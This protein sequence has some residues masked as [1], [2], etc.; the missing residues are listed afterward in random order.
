MFGRGSFVW[1]YLK[2]KL[3]V[4]C[5]KTADLDPSK[6]Y[7]LG[8]HPHGILP[9]G[10]LTAFMDA[11]SDGFSKLFPSVDF[12]IL[13][14]SFCFY[15]PIYRDFLLSCGVIDASRFSAARALNGGK[16]L[17]IVPGGGKRLN[18]FTNW[19]NAKREKRSRLSWHGMSLTHVFSHGSLA[20]QPKRRCF[21]VEQTNWV[22]QTG[23]GKWS[24]LSSCFHFCKPREMYFLV[25]LLSRTR[26]TPMSCWMWR[27]LE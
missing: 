11:G 26:T 8:L 17:V 15:A 2:K 7:I 25:H 24:P 12:R 10:G 27:I 3:S 14:A 18:L 19:L 13:A 4:R 20:Q 16:S 5:V 21:G 9:L 1:K 6:R 23:P 22:Y